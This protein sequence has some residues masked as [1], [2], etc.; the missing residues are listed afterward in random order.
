MSSILGAL[1]L[2]GASRAGGSCDLASN[3]YICCGTIA[4]KI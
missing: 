4:W 1:S 2:L 3:R